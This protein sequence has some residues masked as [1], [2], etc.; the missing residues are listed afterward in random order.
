MID[1]PTER[2]PADRR[3]V[4]VHDDAWA[5]RYW[6]NRFNCSEEQLRAAISVV[7]VMAD[8]IDEYLKSQR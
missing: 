6:C 4:N 8:T 3:R 5:L 7:G 2:G 1:D